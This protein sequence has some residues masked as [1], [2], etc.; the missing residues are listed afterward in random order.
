MNK[1]KR[2]ELQEKEVEIILRLIDKRVKLLEE[3]IVEWQDWFFYD[4]IPKEKR[5]IDEKIKELYVQLK[6]VNRFKKTIENRKSSLSTQL[7]PFYFPSD[8]D[9]IN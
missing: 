4:L 8:N 9:N 5:K 1:Q 2:L 3:K 6:E 7:F